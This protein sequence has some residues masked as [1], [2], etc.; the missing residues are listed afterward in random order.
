MGEGKKEREENR[1]KMNMKLEFLHKQ[2]EIN[3]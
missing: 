1:D 2:I 3:R